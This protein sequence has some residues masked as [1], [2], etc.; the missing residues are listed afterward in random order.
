MNPHRPRKSRKSQKQDKRELLFEIC[1]GCCPNCGRPLQ[2]KRSKERD[3]Y[4][5]IDHVV[6]K[7]N[8]GTNHLYNLAPLCRRCNMKKSDS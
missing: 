6:A 1:G 3:S 4:M 8:G 5:T 2:N 7:S